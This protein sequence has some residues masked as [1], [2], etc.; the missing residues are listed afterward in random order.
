MDNPLKNNSKKGLIIAGV[1][2]G[3]LLA[4][5]ARYFYG[6]NKTDIEQV[7][8]ELKERARDYMQKKARN[9]VKSDLKGL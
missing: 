3:A 4:G 7:T 6:R 5:V 9:R 8:D 1:T 2:V